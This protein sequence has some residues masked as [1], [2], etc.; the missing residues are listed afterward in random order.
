MPFKSSQ[1]DQLIRRRRFLSLLANAA[2]GTVAMRASQSTLAEAKKS[3]SPETAKV[4]K[5]KSVLEVKGSVLLNDLRSNKSG[6]KKA[7]PIES[8]STLEFEES[9][10]MVSASECLA[11]QQ[12]QAAQ[13]ENQIEK[14]ATNL[15]LREAC[16][17][18]VK[19]VSDAGA[20]TSCFNHPLTVGERDL[21]EG[22]I[23]TMFLDRLMPTKPVEL[24]DQW[25]LDSD[26]AKKLF[27]LD[28]LRSGD[29]KI[30]L[31]ESTEEQ[32][33]LE[34]AGT[35]QGDVQDVATKLRIQGKARIDRKAG[36]IDWLALLLEEE[37][38]VGEAR[39]GFAVQARLRV[40]RQK[41]DG[42][43][44]GEKLENLES[45][46]AKLDPNAQLM[47]FDSKLGAYKFVADRNWITILDS[48]VD[49]T[50]KYVNGNRTLAYCT[51]TN[52][53]DREPG[54][55]LSMEG[56]QQDI[57][58]TLGNKF[59]QFLEAG[60]KV[61]QSGLRMMRVVTLG[62]T[63]GVQVQWIN[64][65]LSNDGGRHISLAYTMNQ[66]NAESFGTQD[67][68]MAGSLEFSLKQLPSSPTDKK[69]KPTE[70]EATKSASQTPGSVLRN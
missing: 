17:E 65:L 59:T 18:V 70:T 62:H 40:L 33:Q 51:I 63:E 49:A 21:V 5:I 16:K 55:Q 12:F 45:L 2:V 47:Q 8:K 41:I 13:L 11:V 26:T 22:P 25:L 28:L 58:K 23:A 34:L 61:S 15:T 50:L 36:V 14:H 43:S 4:F 66:S 19:R 64:I 31:I 52:L 67:M 56:F 32:G 24:G 27:R 35:L 20:V 6:T 68:Q 29:L 44:S 57:Q 3:S 7:S 1:L 69:D 60:E 9:Y 48:G 10:R 38:D 53:A 46:I 39:P 54:R 37:R 42:L 30:T